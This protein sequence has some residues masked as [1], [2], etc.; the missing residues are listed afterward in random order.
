MPQLGLL[1]SAQHAEDDV[2][3]ALPLCVVAL[4]LTFALR[5]SAQ[6]TAAMVIMQCGTVS[7]AVNPPK[8]LRH[9]R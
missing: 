1:G 4:V 7:Q 6:L 5:A 2:Q 3:L 9:N 8:T